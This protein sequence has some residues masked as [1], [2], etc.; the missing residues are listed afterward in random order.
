[1]I[2]LESSAGVASA[3]RY[4]GT[5]YAPVPQLYVLPDWHT[6]G[7]AVLFEFDDPRMLEEYDQRVRNNVE[8]LN[9]TLLIRAQTIRNEIGSVV[10]HY[11]DE[12]RAR[13][14]ENILRRAESDRIYAAL[15][16]DEI[17][18]SPKVEHAIVE[19]PAERPELVEP[20]VRRSVRR[21]SSPRRDRAG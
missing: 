6:Y 16:F 21:Q 4:K 13:T 7:P 8:S 17:G 2:P 1:V 10:E 14:T 12:A 9:V 19:Q 15:P 5:F 11:V 20:R 3:L 18:G